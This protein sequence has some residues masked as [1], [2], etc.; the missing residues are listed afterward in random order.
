M[1]ESDSMITWCAPQPLMLSNN[2]PTSP[3][4]RSSASRK[5]GNLLGVTRTFQPGVSGSLPSR[6]AHTS[7]GV[8]PSLSGQKGQG[9]A[10]SEDA[11][12][13]DC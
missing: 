11:D 5:A 1:R 7:G 2:R 10:D 3:R 13:D 4:E 12:L 6:K 9:S 8:S